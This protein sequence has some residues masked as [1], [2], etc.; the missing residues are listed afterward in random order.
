MADTR[1]SKKYKVCAINNL[2]TER[3]VWRIYGYPTVINFRNKKNVFDVIRCSAM[4]DLINCLDITLAVIDNLNSR[5][6]YREQG[7]HVFSSH[8]ILKYYLFLSLKKI[9]KLA[10]NII[11]P[12]NPYKKKLNCFIISK[13]STENKFYREMS[14]FP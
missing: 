8:T 2:R 13:H 14:L 4:I 11:L 12:K 3:I 5:S 1:V 7:N 6:L 10:Y 9:I